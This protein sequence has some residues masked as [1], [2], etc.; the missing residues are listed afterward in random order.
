MALIFIM[1]LPGWTK[2]TWGPAWNQ[3]LEAALN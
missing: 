1:E 3:G 2:V